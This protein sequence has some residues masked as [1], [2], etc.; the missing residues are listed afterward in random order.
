MVLTPAVPLQRGMPEHAI[1]DDEPIDLIGD[2]RCLAQG[3]CAAC[4][5]QMP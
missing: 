4:I 2:P 3:I 5:A 1:S